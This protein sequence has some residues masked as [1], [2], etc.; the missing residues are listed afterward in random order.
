MRRSGSRLAEL[1]PAVILDS[2]PE[3]AFDEISR[4]LATTLAVQH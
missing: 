2:A 4:L 3:R 1:H